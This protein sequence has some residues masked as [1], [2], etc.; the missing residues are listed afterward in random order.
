MKKSVLRTFLGEAS[1]NVFFPSTCRGFFLAAT[2]FKIT[3]LKSELHHPLQGLSAVS[4][5]TSR[6]I[7]SREMHGYLPYT[8]FTSFFP[9]L[10][11]EFFKNI[12]LYSHDKCLVQKHF[13]IF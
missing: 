9:Q 4:H 12:Y 3:H 2:L 1:N 7:N 13:E 10:A 11:L 6:L 5:S 8:N